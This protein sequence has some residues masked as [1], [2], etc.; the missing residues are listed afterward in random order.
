MEYMIRLTQQVCV[1]V[2][3]VNFDE[4]FM[5]ADQEL[6]LCCGNAMRFVWVSKFAAWFASN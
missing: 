5:R 3:G 6:W 2:H 4:T 1:C